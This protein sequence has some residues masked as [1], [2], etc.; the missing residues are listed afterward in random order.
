MALE[1]SADELPRSDTTNGVVA[2]KVK[3]SAARASD[4]SRKRKCPGVPQR[5]LKRERIHCPHQQV[6]GTVV[7]SVGRN[8]ILRVC[9]EL[10]GLVFTLCVPDSKQLRLSVPCQLFAKDSR[11]YDRHTVP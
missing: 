9:G 2:C 11:K 1:D 6:T 4:V 7:L 3:D 5:I 8:M 10:G